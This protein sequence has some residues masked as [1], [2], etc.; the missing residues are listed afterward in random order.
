MKA[1]TLHNE[2]VATG[3]TP[4]DQA[5]RVLVFVHGRGA[6]AG[7]ILTLGRALDAA[8]YAWV[9]P[10][11]PGHTW[12]PYRFM[13]PTAQNEPYLSESLGLL[14]A[15]HAQLN[16]AG[17]SDDRICWLGF[18]QGACLTTEFCARHA[19]RWGGI[20]AFTGGLIGER[21]DRERYEGDL[22][23]TPVF[24]G[25]S[26]PDPH[27]PPQRVRDTAAVLTDLGAVVTQ[28]IY[29]LMGHTINDDEI[30]HANT[31]LSR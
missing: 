7:S 9:A 10:Q 14:Q 18:S 24:M 1:L 3:G 8:N 28:Q 6:T 30:A 16:A 23:E 2:P 22:A 21:I 15:L 4:L 11:A 25:S 27:V 31:I 20:I 19:R 17:F 5:E 26:D 13:A 12:Y 29:P